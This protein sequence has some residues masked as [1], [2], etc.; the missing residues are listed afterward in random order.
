MVT[1]IDS[2]VLLDVLLDDASYAESSKA[3][4]HQAHAEGSLIICETVLAEICPVL[5]PKEVS[6]FLSDWNLNFAPSTRDSAILAGQMFQLYLERGGK[7]SRVVADFLIG[8]HAQMH[9]ARLLARDRGFYRDYFKKLD[10]WDPSET[11]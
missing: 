6:P 5:G 9:S 8:A 2:S 4:L 11:R 10:L 1:A 7:R 3:A